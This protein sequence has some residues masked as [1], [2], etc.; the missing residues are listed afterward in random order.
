MGIHRWPVDSPHKGSVTWKA[1]HA[2]TSSYVDCMIAVAARVAHALAPLPLCK[3]KNG[4]PPL[5]IDGGDWANKPANGNLL[6]IKI[7]FIIP[8]FMKLSLCGSNGFLCWNSL[9]VVFGSLFQFVNLPGYFEM[10]YLKIKNRPLC[11]QVRIEISPD[12]IYVS[13]F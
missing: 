11:P 4:G 8:W 9:V 12:N 7:H 2:M 1:F 6:T 5:A 13:N 3:V 10:P